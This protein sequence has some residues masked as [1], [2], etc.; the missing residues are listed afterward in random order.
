[1]YAKTNIKN[2]E[3]NWSNENYRKLS[4][5]HRKIRAERITQSGDKRETREVLSQNDK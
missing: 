3:I 4:L 1:M 5:E 2:V